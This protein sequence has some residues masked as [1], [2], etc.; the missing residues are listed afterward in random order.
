MSEEFDFGHGPVQ[1]HRH[2]YGGGWVANTATVDLSAYVGANARVYDN[3]HVYDSARVYGNA[4]VFGDTH[5]YDNARVYGNAKVYG[6]ARVYDNARVFGNAQVHGKAQV[7]GN[8]R[9]CGND[10]WWLSGLEYSVTYTKLDD[11]L[12]IGCQR[13]T[14]AEWISYLDAPGRNRA[15]RLEAVLRGV[16]SDRLCPADVEE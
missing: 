15:P 1:A 10:I 3:A 5:V 8:A 7:F 2:P 16:F 9:V 12:A 11:C 6:N 13:R 14:V 4:R